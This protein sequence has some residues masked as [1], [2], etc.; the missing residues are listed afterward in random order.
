M[1]FEKG[2]ENNMSELSVRDQQLAAYRKEQEEISKKFRTVEANTPTVSLSALQKQMQ[3][4]LN[5]ITVL[6]LGNLNLVGNSQRVVSNELDYKLNQLYQV[7]HKIRNE[8]KFS[9]RLIL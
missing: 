7:I 4:L 9:G 2:S 6:N 5:E 1:Q 3:T 8:N